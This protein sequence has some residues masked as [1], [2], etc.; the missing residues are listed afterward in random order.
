MNKENTCF[1]A[2]QL[3]GGGQKMA[4]EAYKMRYL[5]KDFSFYKASLFPVNSV[6]VPL[7]RFPS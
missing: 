6:L 1:D 3:P 7:F 2:L 4:A 5:K